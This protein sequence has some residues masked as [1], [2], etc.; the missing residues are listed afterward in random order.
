[1]KKQIENEIRNRLMLLMSVKN[2]DD[3]E[4]LSQD[5][6][7]ASMVYQ[8]RMTQLEVNLLDGLGQM[9]SLD[10]SSGDVGQKIRL[11]AL[12]NHLRPMYDMWIANVQKEMEDE[13]CPD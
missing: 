9:L 13:I 8:N 11:V 12:L 1:M 3:V 5:L 6:V 10:L 4:R 2:P 7:D